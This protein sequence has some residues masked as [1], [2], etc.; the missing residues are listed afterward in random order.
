M[1]PAG[2]SP[3]QSVNV[4]FVL[5]WVSRLFNAFVMFDVCLCLLSET[6]YSSRQ[7]DCSVASVWNG[8]S[9]VFVPNI[10]LELIEES[11]KR[12]AL[13]LTKDLL[14]SLHPT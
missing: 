14:R 3:V 12:K 1:P 8:S 6:V 5:F 9:F 11:V 2:S 7:A 10:S 13:I 4:V